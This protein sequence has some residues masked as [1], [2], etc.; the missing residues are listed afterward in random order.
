MEKLFAN[1]HMAVYKGER[2]MMLRLVLDRVYVWEVNG[3]LRIG[4]EVGFGIITVVSSVFVT[5]SSIQNV[6]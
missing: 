6:I 3:L 5:P 1:N 2:M 4:L